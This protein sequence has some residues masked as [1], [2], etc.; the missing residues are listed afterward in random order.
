[1]RYLEC[2]N[3]WRCGVIFVMFAD[4]SFL[5]ITA[6]VPRIK[7]DFV[8]AECTLVSIWLFRHEPNEWH[9]KRPMRLINA[10]WRSFL[11]YILL[12]EGDSCF[13]F[14]FSAKQRI[15][16]KFECNLKMSGFYITLIVRVMCMC[17][18]ISII[19]RT[20]HQWWV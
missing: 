18:Y 14:L 13:L 2:Y 8:P 3:R 20:S 10:R 6:R 5:Q 16:S 4:K 12:L 7:V 19:L 15:I 9:S 17:V 11:L 1:M